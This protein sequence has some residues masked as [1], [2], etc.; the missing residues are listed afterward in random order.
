MSE[1]FGLSGSATG[2]WGQSTNSSGIGVKGVNTAGGL[3]ARFEG[4][5]TTISDGGSS[6][7]VGLNT[8][9][10]LQPIS[11][12]KGIGL[13]FGSASATQS[14]ASI[15]APGREIV[16]LDQSLLFFTGL[17]DI[18]V[19]PYSSAK[20]SI[21][22]N[23]NIGV[24]TTNPRTKFHVAG[25]GQFDGNVGIGM[26]LPTSSELLHVE[27]NTGA[28]AGSFVNNNNTNTND[29]L[30]ALHTGLGNAFRAR[31]TQV[32]GRAGLFETTN[33]NSSSPTLETSAVGSGPALRA[34][35]VGAGPAGVFVGN[36]NVNGTLSA[37]S[38]NAANLTSAGTL[39]ASTNPV[40][41]TQLKN[42]PAPLASGQL[43]QTINGLSSDLTLAA[44]ND[45]A[46]AIAGNT[47]TISSIAVPASNPL[48]LAT[49]HWY[50]AST[51]AVFDVPGNLAGI[52][53][54]G[55]N[56]WVALDSAGSGNQVSKVRASDGAVLGTYTA[57]PA[58]TWPYGIAFDGA[59]IW[60]SAENGGVTKLRA[61]DGVE[62]GTYAAGNAPRRLAFDGSNIWVANWEG[63]TV[64]KIRASDGS[65]QGSYAVGVNPHGVAFDGNNIWVTSQA[66]TVMK[67]RTA[68]GANLATYNVG[69]GANDVAFDGTNMWVATECGVVKKLRASDGACPNGNCTFSVGNTPL[70]GI[71]F[72]GTNVWVT[73]RYDGTVTKLRASDGSIQGTI[74]STTP[75]AIAFDGAFVW[76]TNST[77]GKL[78]KY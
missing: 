71:V 70:L 51:N 26:V 38:L 47:L 2:L 17:A 76:V 27:A 48:Q 24:G 77:V 11:Q 59:N 73:G 9:L 62:L 78:S 1:I 29:A 32:S 63:G 46:I 57:G 42:V 12:L 23:G 30:F 53:F 18:P 69:C 16:P 33:P 13:G 56:M 40:D 22:S 39:N 6:N 31:N 7:D 35:N 49:L 66:G 10:R 34:I 54:D 58:G 50:S 8:I 45:V 65:N 25:A 4:N 55:A 60:V 61:S 68:D 28:V 43:V 74:P 64:T 67:L 3:A 52:G 37:T 15:V 75:Y 21:M 14:R 20:L 19:Q 5:V 36:V 44:G 41:W 72:D